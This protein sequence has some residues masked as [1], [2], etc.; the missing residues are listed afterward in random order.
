[1]E[2]VGIIMVAAPA[3]APA[4]EEMIAAEGLDA[5]DEEQLDAKLDAKV[6]RAV[7]KRLD[8]RERKRKAD[9]AR[10]SSVHADA[11]TI[12]PDG[13]DY[14]VS[15]TA[16]AVDAIAKADPSKVER[17]RKLAAD[18]KTNPVHEGMLRQML[19]DLR[20]S[21]SDSTPT[22]IAKTS[23]DGSDEPYAAPNMPKVQS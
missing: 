1:M 14:S 6:E 5:D 9:S 17:A 2:S 23:A 21:S 12:L 8:A 20:R 22:T 3:E 11:R 19:A 4:E 16:V 10:E 7:A 13:Y 15:W 18:A